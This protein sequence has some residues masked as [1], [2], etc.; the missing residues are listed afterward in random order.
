[1]TQQD[2]IHLRNLAAHGMIAE[3]LLRD[4]GVLEVVRENIRRWNESNGP[5]PALLSRKRKQSKRKHP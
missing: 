5:M 1:M 4:P 3:K 2:R